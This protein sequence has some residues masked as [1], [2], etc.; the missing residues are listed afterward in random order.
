MLQRKNK[1]WT[2]LVFIFMGVL[3]W[4]KC[5]D[6]HSEPA[7][8]VSKDLNVEVLIKEPD[9]I[10]P[11]TMAVDDEGSIY[12]S[13]SHTY[14]YGKEGSPY[15]SVSNPIK[16]ILLDEQGE[17]Q[18]IITVAEGF[19]DPVMG[20]AIDED[21]LFI[22]NLNQISVVKLDENDRVEHTETLIRDNTTPWNPFGMYR[23]IIGPDDKLW[24]SVAD[25]PSS[26]PVVLTGTDGKTVRLSGQSGGI[27]RCDR[28]G[29]NL[30]VMVEGLRAP[31]AFEVDPWG[32]LWVISNG[33]GSPNIY[34]EAIFGMDYGYHSRDVTYNWLA[35]KTTLSPPVV[36]MGAGANTATLTYRSTHFS[37]KYEGDV[38]MSNWGNHGFNPSNRVIKRIPGSDMTQMRSAESAGTGHVFFAPVHDSLFRPTDIKLLPDGR[39]LISDWQGRDDESNRRGRIYRISYKK[40]VHKNG[41]DDLDNLKN[42]VTQNEPIDLLDHPNHWVRRQVIKYWAQAGSIPFHDFKALLAGGSAVASANA[43]WILTQRSE[44]TAEKLMEEALTHEDARVRAMSIR[45]LRQKA[46]LGLVR[47]NNLGPGRDSNFGSKEHLDSLMRPFLQD[48]AVEVRMEAALALFYPSDIVSGLKQAAELAEDK[49][50]MYRIGFELGK[51]CDRSELEQLPAVFDDSRQFILGVCGETILHRRPELSDAIKAWGIPALKYQDQAEQLVEQVRT[52]TTIEISKEKR[53]VLNRLNEYPIIDTIFQDFIL[54]CLS[55]ENAGVKKAALRAV[56]NGAFEREDLVEQTLWIWNNSS[57]SLV[58]MEA[59]YTIGSFSGKYNLDWSAIMEESTENIVVTALRVLR[60][61]DGDIGRTDSLERTLKKIYHQMPR[62]SDEILLTN[63]AMGF[64]PME[65]DKDDNDQKGNQLKHIYSEIYHQIDNASAA[66]GELLF[67]S[68]AAA[69]SSCHATSESIKL[70]KIGPNLSGLGGATQPQYLV[71]SIL[72]PGKVIKTGYRMERI[73][74]TSDE[75]WI[76]I[77]ENNGNEVIIHTLGDT[78]LQLNQSE[79]ISRR[80]IEPS[81]MP[82]GYQG[83]MTILELSDLVKYLMSLKSDG[84]N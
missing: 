70:K 48:P 58:R 8:D 62:L 26:A 60:T 49:Y 36:D 40:P 34:F 21:Q 71:E 54:E 77:P 17:V 63:R 50:S 3:L 1:I 68:K 57:D 20:I 69:C 13:L 5:Q 35:G 37:E 65:G 41:F 47:K 84:I 67:H 80:K 46:G 74:T 42:I 23:V 39:L 32:H 22:T 30:E 43:L 14:R 4:Q 64:A 24:F 44:S 45:Q 61:L 28:D 33:E 9:I 6:R 55:D 2:S 78:V 73:E 79:I 15:D 51:F 76:G 66:R 31:Y 7:E 27:L 25:R 72:E 81:I 75:I 11:M 83:R 12:V 19:Q 59:L 52:G 82:G 53:M 16:K 18:N 56:R 10:N 29:A 38:F